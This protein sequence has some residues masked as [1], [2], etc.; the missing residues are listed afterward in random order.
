MLEDLEEF[1]DSS[2]DGKIDF[3]FLVSI[4]NFLK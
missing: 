2:G 4:V 1:V 3:I